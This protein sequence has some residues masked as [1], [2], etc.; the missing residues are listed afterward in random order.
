MNYTNY[1]KQL[2]ILVRN[3]NSC[4]CLCTYILVSLKVSGLI[5]W[6]SYIDICK[7]FL[8]IFRHHSKF[9]SWR[10]N[11]NRMSPEIQEI[12]RSFQA[13]VINFCCYVN[14]T[15]IRYAYYHKAIS[16]QHAPHA[17]V[18]VPSPFIALI[19]NYNSTQYNTHTKH[20]WTEH[21]F[22]SV[23]SCPQLTGPIPIR[24]T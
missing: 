17:H 1:R 16:A 3:V 8:K 18:F 22:R 15:V 24:I 9:F 6:T 2:T 20:K 23:P 7:K 4:S 11:F 13:G 19:G 12:H 10:P 14:A 21:P 5:H